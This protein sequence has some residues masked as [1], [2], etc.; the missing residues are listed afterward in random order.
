MHQTLC[1]PL[2][3]WVE[4][5]VARRALPCPLSSGRLCHPSWQSGQPPPSLALKL[6]EVELASAGWVECGVGIYE[7]WG[8]FILADS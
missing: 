2:K 5:R 8:Y 4:A 1:C 6:S 7:G 3:R